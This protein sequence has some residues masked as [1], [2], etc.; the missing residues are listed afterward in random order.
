MTDYRSIVPDEIILTRDPADSSCA[1]RSW[2]I[3]VI[4]ISKNG[5]ACI[6]TRDCYGNDGIPGSEFH[7]LILVYP[8][9]SSYDGARVID[10]EALRHDLSDGGELSVLIDRIILGHEIEWNGNNYVGVLSGDAK[11]ADT[12]LSLIDDDRYVSTAAVW[13]AKEWLYSGGDSDA[14]ILTYLGLT[15]KATD[16]EIESASKHCRDEVKANGGVLIGDVERAIRAIIETACEEEE[17]F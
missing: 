8:F 6:E 13:D 9:A 17:D 2:E 11:D 5:T 1:A 15:T 12:D 14:R 16:D 3:A 4:R 10:V 7:G